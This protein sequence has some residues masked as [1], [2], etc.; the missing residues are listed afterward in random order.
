MQTQQLSQI[1][2]L[3]RQFSLVPRKQYFCKQIQ[4]PRELER[5]A[6]DSCNEAFQS[7]DRDGSE[8]AV[9]EM[10]YAEEVV[11]R[12]VDELITVELTEEQQVNLSKVLVWILNPYILSS[13]ACEPN[14]IESENLK[15]QWFKLL[16]KPVEM[17]NGRI[18]ILGLSSAALI[19]IVEGRTLQN[20]FQVYYQGPFLAF[21]LVV[22][23]TILR[24]WIWTPPQGFGI[25]T[26]NAELWSGRAAMFWFV[27]MAMYESWAG[28]YGQGQVPAQFFYLLGQFLASEGQADC[29]MQAVLWGCGVA[30]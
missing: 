4:R 18:A 2:G 17:L 30:E 29:E 14:S 11:D 22:V 19:Q 26:R 24:Q 7:V 15:S 6:T 8:M 16:L 1:R 28:I 13:Y 12:M 5:F 3:Q 23:I 21:G 9:K 25:F 10:V 20:Q 27:V